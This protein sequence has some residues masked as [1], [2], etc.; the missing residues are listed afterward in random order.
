MISPSSS[1]AEAGERLSDEE[2][3]EAF[4]RTAHSK[5]NC[6]YGVTLAS[7]PC[8]CTCHVG[9]IRSHIHALQNRLAEV[10]AALEQVCS[11]G[12]CICPKCGLRHGLAA[13][14]GGF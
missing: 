13:T 12:D 6:L 10:E 14:Y 2:L 9:K 7:G 4:R 5:Y 1:S 3:T 8:K 11:I